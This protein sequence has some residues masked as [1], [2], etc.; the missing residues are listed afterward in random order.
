MKILLITQYFYPEN[1][2]SNDIAF[3]LAKKGHK[4]TVLTGLP[5]YPEGKIYKGYGFF[6]RRNEEIE[7]VKV[8]RSLLIPRSKG[9]GI[10]LFL[11]YFSW[12]FFASLKAFFLSFSEKFDALIVHEPSP[13][14]QGFP[15]SG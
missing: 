14:T 11:N 9:G 12:A 15:T 7:G 8:I 4:V 13:I 10:R 2:K 5:N 3:E 1:F 6:K